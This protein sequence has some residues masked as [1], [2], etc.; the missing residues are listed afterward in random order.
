MGP[1]KYRPF[2]WLALMPDEHFQ[3]LVST[4]GFVPCDVVV[5]HAIES[6]RAAV[7]E[8][9]DRRRDAL[10]VIEVEENH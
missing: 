9:I 5:P 2:A 7:E 3:A 6:F 10:D 8:E 4:V 1:R